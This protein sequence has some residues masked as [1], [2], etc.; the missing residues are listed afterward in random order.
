VDVGEAFQEFSLNTTLYVCG[1]VVERTRRHVVVGDGNSTHV[2]HQ[3]ER[4]PKPA[5][6]QFDRDRGGSGDLAFHQGAL[7]VCLPGEVV[8]RE[9]AAPGRREARHVVLFQ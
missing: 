7:H 2:L 5:F 9:D 8:L 4:T 6:V 3:E 1:L